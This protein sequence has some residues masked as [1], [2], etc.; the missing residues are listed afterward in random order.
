VLQFVLLRRYFR[1][2]VGVFQQSQGRLFLFLIR[3]PSQ[4]RKID[5]MLPAQFIEAAIVGNAE[6]P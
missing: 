1:G 2:W 6:E 3:F 4:F 5:Y